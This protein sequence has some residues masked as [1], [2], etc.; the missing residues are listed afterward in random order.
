MTGDDMPYM[1]LKDDGQLKYFQ[2]AFLTALFLLNL[3]EIAGQEYFITDF[4]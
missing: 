1:H 4:S 2:E 3:N